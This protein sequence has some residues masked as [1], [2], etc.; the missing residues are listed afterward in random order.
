MRDN[1][2]VTKYLH[3]N[4]DRHR[5][6]PKSWHEHANGA[7]IARKIQKAKETTCRMRIFPF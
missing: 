3:N 2:P 7:V 4:C 5:F 1:V 6:G